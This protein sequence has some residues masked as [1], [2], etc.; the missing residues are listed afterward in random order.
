MNTN[1]YAKLL[2]GIKA[3]VRAAESRG[4]RVVDRQSR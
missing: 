2:D 4:E 3:R 1:D